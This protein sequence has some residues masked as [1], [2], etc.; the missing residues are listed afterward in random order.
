MTRILNVDDYDP[1]RYGRTRILRQAGF[2]VFEATTG[3]EA[4]R[5]VE[6]KPNLVL[7]DINLPDMSGLEVCRRIKEDPSTA[8]TLILHLTASNMMPEHRAYGLNNGAD[9][10]LTEPVDPEVLLATIR[11]LLR[12]QAAE[13]ALKRSNEELRNFTNMLSHELR[14]PLRSITAFT[15]LLGK[16]LKGRLDEREEEYLAH[17][18]DGALRM[19][20]FLESV[21]LYCKTEQ[22]VADV[23]VVS[24]ENAFAEAVQGLALLIRESGAQILHEPLPN[25]MANKV[26]LKAVFSNLLSNSIKYRSLEPVVIRVSATVQGNL[27]LFIVQDNGIGIDSR[28]H[29]RVFDVFKRLHGSE[30]PGTG[31][32][33]SVCKRIIE[34]MGGNIWVNSEP[35][36]GSRFFF[37]LPTA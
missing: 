30:Y 1:S 6:Q 12:V 34:N 10:Y 37:T 7:L 5:A 36:K 26:T 27:V 17:A 16:S 15:Q 35:G 24:A 11:S 8:S 22:S 28:F 13:E 29:S 23:S 25:V 2:E 32:G 31:L 14:E 21:F 20:T 9:G 4:L 19:G 33:L 3:N 18:I